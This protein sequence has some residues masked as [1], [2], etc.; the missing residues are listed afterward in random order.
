MRFVTRSRPWRAAIVA[1]ALAG[2]LAGC[3]RDAGHAPLSGQV[4]ANATSVGAIALPEVHA[5]SPDTQFRFQPPAGHVLLVYFG[6]TTCPDVCP[7][8]LTEVHRALAK[9][10]DDAHRV[11]LAFVTVDPVRD[12][13]GQLAPYVATFVAD[14][15]ALRPA[16]HQ[17]LAEAER[18]FGATSS[19]TQDSSGNVEVSHS[20]TGY[21][22]DPRGRIAV[23]WPFGTSVDAMLHD[24]R[25][26]LPRTAR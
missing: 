17:Q 9:L 21:V 25:A 4:P 12:T 2:W 6:Y 7:M 16:S 5:N 22:V 14:G 23:E 24:L 11:E 10:G 20:G 15:H 26:L 18:A 19:V 13:P 3:A 8:T 1:L